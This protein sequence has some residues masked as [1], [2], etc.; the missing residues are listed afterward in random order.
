MMNHDDMYK[1]EMVKERKITM[2]FVMTR[3][4]L[5]K[6]ITTWMVMIKVNSM[7]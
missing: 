1:K 2:S 3:V 4:T 6:M 7:W 5:M